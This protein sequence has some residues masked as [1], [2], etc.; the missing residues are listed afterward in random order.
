MA[1]VGTIKELSGVAKAVS[2]DGTTRVLVV[3][4]SINEGDVVS[5]VGS[6]SSVKLS[7]DNGKELI[8]SGDERALL[9]QSVISSE[10]VSDPDIQAAQ[11]AILAG[12]ELPDE[13]TAAGDGGAQGEGGFTEAYTADRSD[14]RGDVSTYN[15]GTDGPVTPPIQS[16]DIGANQPPE[17]TDDFAEAF[18]NVLY[19]GNLLDNDFDDGLPNPPGGLDVFSVNGIGDTNGDGFI[20]I[21]TEFGE[22]SVNVDTGDYEYISNYDPL[23]YGENV[24]ET[25]EYVV[26]DGQLTDT[27]TLEIT[28]NGT[29]DQPEADTLLDTGWLLS[30][31]GGDEEGSGDNDGP[32]TL[33]VLAVE[34]SVDL[35]EINNFIGGS[36]GA[37]DAIDPSEDPTNGSALK[38]TV[39]VEAG[40][41]VN[42]NW[43]FYDAEEEGQNEYSDFSFVVIDGQ[44]IQLLASAFDAGAINNGVF[45]HTFADAGNHEIVF[46]VMNEDDTAV[47]P[48]LQV[49]H[50]SGGT[51][52]GEDSIGVVE[53]TGDIY[54][55]SDLDEVDTSED[56]IVANDEDINVL[57]GS[58]LANDLDA[59][60]THIFRLIDMDAENT[61]LVAYDS[62]NDETN[63]NSQIQMEVS[64]T[65]IDTEALDIQSITLFTN[66]QEDRVSDFEIKGDFGALGVGESATITF[67]FVADDM[68]GFGEGELPNE[69]SISEPMTVTMTVLGTNDQPVVSDVQI[70]VT[71]ASL[72][73]IMPPSEGE[74][75]NFT[76]QDMISMEDYSYTGQLLVSDDDVNDM[77]L[78]T[79]EWNPESFSLSLSTSNAIILNLIAEHDVSPENVEEFI[80][81]MTEGFIDFSYEDNNPTDGVMES[82][83]L[84]TVDLSPELIGYLLESGF[85]NIDVQED[86]QFSVSSLLFNLLGAN[87]SISI[88]FDYRADDTRGQNGTD[89]YNEDSVSEWAT[90]TLT[91]DGT[92]DQPVA[93]PF[94]TTLNESSLI[95]IGD[96][97]DVRFEGTLAGGQEGPHDF[98]PL[99]GRLFGEMDEDL[100]DIATMKY[101][102]GEAEVLTVQPAEGRYD[103][104]VDTIQT[105]VHVNENGTFSIENPTFDNLAYGESVTVTFDYYIDDMSDNDVGEAHDTSE[106]P[107]ELTHSEPQSITVTIM[108]TNDQPVIQSVA[109]TQ[110][111]YYEAMGVPSDSEDA[112]EITGSLTQDFLDDDTNDIPNLHYVSIDDGVFN[113]ADNDELNASVNLQVV[114]EIYN[115]SNLNINASDINI[116]LDEDGNFTLISDKF[117]DLGEGES[118]DVTFYVKITDESNSTNGESIES[119]TKVVTVHIEGTNDQPVVTAVNANGESIVYEEHNGLNTFENTLPDAVDNDVNDTHEYF[120]VEG[121]NSG[122]DYE[123][124][125]PVPV[126]ITNIVVNTDGTYSVVGDF[127][128]LA[129]GEEAVVTFEYYAVDSSTTQLNGEPNISEPETVTLT[130]TGT[131]DAPVITTDSGT[132]VFFTSESAGFDNTLIAYTLNSNGEPENP[133]VVV[134][135]SK[136]GHSNGDLMAE[137]DASIDDVHFAIIAQGHNVYE[138]IT[139]LA[140]DNSGAYPVL[141]VNGSTSTANVYYDINEFNVGGNDHFDVTDN[142]DGTFTISMED[143]DLGD[144]DRVDLV[145]K[146]VGDSTEGYVK[147]LPDGDEYENVAILKTTGSLTFDDVDL[148]DSHTIRVSSDVSGYLGTFIPIISEAATGSAVGEIQWSFEVNDADVDY[149]AEG[150]TLTQTYTIE[151]DDGHGGTDTQD[152]AI[153]IEGTNDAPEVVGTSATGLEDSTG[154]EVVLSGSDVDGYIDFFTISSEPA[155][156]TLW[157]GTTQL[158]TGDTV[159]ASAD[160]ATVIFVP[161]ENWSGDTSFNYTATDNT[162]STD[163][164][165]AVANIN[166]DPVADAPELSISISEGVYTEAVMNELGLSDFNIYAYKDIDDA[167]YR[168]AH[169]PDKG[170]YLENDALNDNKAV[171][172]ENGGNGIGVTSKYWFFGP[173]YESTNQGAKVIDEGEGVLI[174]LSVSTTS[175]EVS[176]KHALDDVIGWKAYNSDNKLVA[177]GVTPKYSS[178]DSIFEY[179]IDPI[180]DVEFQYITIYATCKSGSGKYGFNIK[181]VTVENGVAEAGYYTYALA[182]SAQLTDSNELLS[183]ISIENMPDSA[184]LYVNG[185][186]ATAVDGVYTVSQNDTIE[187]RSESDIDL[188]S[189]VTSVTSTEQYNIGT[190]N[191]VADD[192]AITTVVN[193]DLDGDTEVVMGLGNDQLIVGDDIEGHASVDMGA[194]NDQLIVGDDIQG[195][196]TVDMGAGNDIVE[197]TGEDDS[198]DTNGRIES[199][200]H[201]DFGFGEDTLILDSGATMLNLENIENLEIVELKGATLSDDIKISDVFSAT[202]EDNELVITGEGE[203]TVDI[204]WGTG[205]VDGDVTVYSSMY[206]SNGTDYAVTLQVDTDL[207]I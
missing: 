106:N 126:S 198:S 75:D 65:D 143:L 82:A 134:A 63:E 48:A 144:N 139:S 184:I 167:D 92:N 59:S 52:V 101:F 42:F 7:F 196:A 175:A 57:S 105:T 205:T 44:E 39:L 94:T 178:N 45:S 70:N 187:V 22:L 197:F 142:G 162:G 125:S 79:F 99:M 166:V 53:T 24:I 170:I 89:G 103:H 158:Y 31:V 21:T 147:E 41:T 14:A 33:S 192:S 84:S 133:V 127:N 131:N 76:D 6:T 40:E 20:V 194:G 25:F 157:L 150:Q 201:V 148:S 200:A 56:N 110:D 130:I 74:Y 55:T 30:V 80:E 15:L 107:H 181:N 119:E 49:V 9:D 140:F 115:G 149:L 34:N 26:T 128:N 135:S 199:G 186:E 160:N 109:T 190:P 78:H 174:D 96:N 168:I 122:I 3:G 206:N 68:H 32:S 95:D 123:V 28:L 87:D 8:L 16:D 81:N 189:I 36:V 180:G 23:A 116:D 85:L 5:T 98:Y 176:F 132:D 145:V 100:L 152:V 43:T 177:S 86:G 18:E 124:D 37:Q 60:D 17:A 120:G 112:R 29:N 67:Q 102:Q 54:E 88:S 1:K 188:S 69:P 35:S 27:A 202:D 172:Y 141:Q 108:G 38:L 203:V 71:E 146:L 113:A 97:E 64:S 195:H 93:Q 10:T 72:D 13:A 193:N 151:V 163:T 179:T 62:G 183:D 114:N 58:L 156:G 161:N 185:V 46:G 138:T 4:D 19:T 171:I 182:L 164:T 121:D 159:D 73:D 77:G 153:T 165:P 66:D 169:G 90:L 191:D 117:N 207:I 104:V 129:F 155:N 173:S 12:G 83:T 136:G 111:N 61:V 50:T 51:I 154:I 2:T 118:L 47:S 204:E 91:I 137:L 11:Q